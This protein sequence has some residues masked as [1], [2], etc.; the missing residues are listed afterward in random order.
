L[1]CVF[2]LLFVVYECSGLSA[3]A[4]RTVR[5]ALSSSCVL[6]FV[7]MMCF[8]LRII[9]VFVASDLQTVYVWDT[10]RPPRSDCPQT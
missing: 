10:D 8:D 9:K 3:G 7:S 1:T 4:V 6:Q 5:E 2:D